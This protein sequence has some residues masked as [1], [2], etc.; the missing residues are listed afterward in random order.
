MVRNKNNHQ[1]LHKVETI[2]DSPTALI[3]TDDGFIG[4]YLSQKLLELPLKLIFLSS[5][6]LEEIQHLKAN[7]RFTE[8]VVKSQTNLRRESFPKLDYIFQVVNNENQK[9]EFSQIHKLTINLLQIAKIN[10]SKFLLAITTNSEKDVKEAISE[11][12][13][14]L[15]AKDS[16]SSQNIK[17]QL[18][19]AV[20]KF[21]KEHNLDARIVHLI[22][23][24]GPIMKI[25]DKWSFSGLL[26]TFRQENK[27]TI[28]GE[29]LTP[30]YPVFVTD[31]ASAIAKA[32]FTERTKGETIFVAGERE[33]TSINL[34]YKLRELVL[35]ESGQMPE[36]LFTETD[37]APQSLSQRMLVKGK[38]VKSR[39][40]LGWKPIV[41]LQ[42]GLT[43]T[44][45]WLKHMPKPEPLET[46]Q[47]AKL[48][49]KTKELSPKTNI[50]MKTP[51][52]KKLK[53][54]F[55]AKNAIV[56]TIL[57]LIVTLIIPPIVFLAT[58]G[59]AALALRKSTL[60]IKQTDINPAI[61]SSK[62]SAALFQAARNQ[63]GLL[64]KAIPKSHKAS[65][66]EVEAYLEAGQLLAQTLKHGAQALKLSSHLKDIIFSES[67][68]KI[69]LVLNDLRR[70]LDSLHSKLSHIELL[71]GEDSEL[72]LDRMPLVLDHKLPNSSEDVKA[73][74]QS[75]TDFRKVM[76]LAPKLL[77]AEGKRTYLILLQ[78]NAELRPTGGFIGSYALVTLEK[79]KLLDFSVEDVYTA[80]GQ[81]KGHVEP[82]AE[83]KEHLGEA[84]WYLRDANWD[85]DFPTA[86][87]KIEW[88]FTKETGR[89]VDG[90]IAINLYVIQEILEALG[91]INLP[92][93]EE[94][95]AADNLFKTA[96]YYS[97]IN[98][99]PGST[100]KKDFLA[101]LSKNM[102]FE[103]EKLKAFK[104]VKLA[105]ALYTSLER[106]QLLVSLHDSKAQQ[107]FNDFGW[108]GSL[109]DVKCE[110]ELDSCSNAFIAIREAN[111][112]V[113]KANYFLNRQISV[114][115]NIKP[116]SI[117]T[118]LT[119][120][121]Q[122]QSPTNKWPG[123]DYKNYLRIYLDE[124]SKVL[125]VR[126]NGET[127]DSSQLSLKA[128]HN[129]TVAGFLVKVP[130][131][132]ESEVTFVTQSNPVRFI[133]D[134]SQISLL[135]QKQP[136]TQNDPLTIELTYPANLVLSST[137]LPLNIKESSATLS[138]NFTQDIALQVEFIR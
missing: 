14:N 33:I 87:R 65:I 88:F 123:G 122:N 5:R 17:Q 7:N 115:Q 6:S 92:D 103:S 121:Y 2:Q 128:Q 106:G 28:K 127:L 45:E 46:A 48:K 37:E 135:L 40:N 126:V 61:N 85:P 104:L 96:E 80:D 114:S 67:D 70:E 10:S 22:H 72:S 117:E 56:G 133:G 20:F 110:K 53:T 51:K 132:K 86:A 71:L 68:N 107:V 58:T 43:R 116:D 31:A 32:M 30:L 124:G 76:L 12:I 47:R 129:K 108:D 63:L 97:E 95:I 27:L 26:K 3:V 90:T 101:S 79:G 113:N 15:L 99:F 42:E 34:A 98:F 112:G 77:A 75:L 74:R 16:E 105:S 91:P 69:H 11:P 66:E 73:L 35:S 9:R 44:L 138:Q 60:K 131:G 4:S 1:P 136:G 52:I 36:I 120:N 82:P 78:N 41:N 25:E 39:E 57:A 119:L 137:N 24:Y 13:G 19:Q 109:K 38:L 8:I 62:R 93:Y 134:K 29:G 59:S 83:I 84:G 130:V 55:K 118:T 111:L 54:A 64:S 125:A 81:L 94:T 21:S 49:H 23:A 102:F 89:K 18:Q 50:Q 100:Q